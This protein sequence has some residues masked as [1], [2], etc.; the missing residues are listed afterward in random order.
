MSDLVKDI[1]FSGIII[2]YVSQNTCFMSQ[3]I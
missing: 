2:S 3:T 1:H